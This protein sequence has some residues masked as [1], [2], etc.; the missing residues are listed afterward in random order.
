MR[1]SL[2]KEEEIKWSF[3]LLGSF[4]NLLNDGFMKYVIIEGVSSK[5][6]IA[7]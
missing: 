1:I 3:E 2:K 4:G 5:L 7:R 6:L